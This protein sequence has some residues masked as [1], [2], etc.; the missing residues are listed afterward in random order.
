M[1]F[2]FSRELYYRNVE[3]THSQENVNE[4]IKI[5]SCLLELEPWKMGVYST[6]KGLIAGPIVIVLAD[7]SLIDCSTHS[8]GRL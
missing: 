2:Y 3:L 7:D 1:L 6:S 5:I 4:A 8:E